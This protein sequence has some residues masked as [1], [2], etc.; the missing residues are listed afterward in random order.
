MAGVL[1]EESTPRSITQKSGEIVTVDGDEEPRAGVT[2]DKLGQWHGVNGGGSTGTA[3][4]A[5]GINDGAAALLL[6]SQS[7]LAT[8]GLTPLARIVATATAGV[9]PRIMGIGPVPA[10]QKALAKAGLHRHRGG[11]RGLGPPPLQPER[12]RGRR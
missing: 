6:A 4:N 10:S 2:L 8:H 5:S 11:L 12:R 1:D 7:A 3:G 9:S